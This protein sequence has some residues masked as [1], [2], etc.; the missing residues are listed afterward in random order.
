MELGIIPDLFNTT[1]ALC[2]YCG[3]RDIEL[4]LYLV[5]VFEKPPGFF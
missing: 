4:G 2:E 5:V 1:K 3:M